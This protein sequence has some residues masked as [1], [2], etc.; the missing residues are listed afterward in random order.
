MLG[1]IIGDI[2]GS[3]F[4]FNP[5]NDYQFELFSPEC[6]F[7]DDTICTIAVADA[8]MHGC[9]THDCKLPFGEFIHKW[10]RKYPHPK[11]G[12]GGR[13]AEWV[14][15]ENPQPYN[16]F[17]NGSA[18]RVSP[19]GWYADSYASAVLL[20]QQ[21]A[22]C[23]HSHPEGIKGAQAVATVIYSCLDKRCAGKELSKEEV[24]LCL[25]LGRLEYPGS[26]NLKIADYRNRFDET[27]QGT[28]PVAMKIIEES[29]SFEDAIRKAVSLGADADTLGAIVGSMAEAIWEIPEWMKEKAMTYLPN[30]MQEILREWDEQAYVRSK[31]EKKEEEKAEKME[32]MTREQ[33]QV[34]VQ[35]A[36]ANWAQAWGNP[37]VG[38]GLTPAPQRP[39]VAATKDDWD[40]EDM[41]T[42]GALRLPV[43]FPLT[44]EQMERIRLG[45]IPAA[46][47]DHWFMYA[48][49]SVIHYYRSWSGCCAFEAHYAAKGD[50]FVVDSV[51]VNCE[52]MN[53]NEATAG[54]EIAGM[55]LGLLWASAN[56]NENEPW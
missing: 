49:E 29:D 8:L 37:N 47:E 35:K 53:L 40:V 27:C 6:S 45:H 56:G 24:E 7:T 21:A 9:K 44:A 32:G 52:I 41:P 38:M 30:E 22:E 51:V 50:G 14:R 5:T 18:M 11:G 3:R 19:V 39:E 31:R 54:Q 28:V 2:A 26:E 15:S 43:E 20:A 33:L 13:F 23:T 4:E 46:Q 10:C 12:Y 25:Y 34:A 16:S 55:F 36:M 48:D 42:E 1:A 17:G